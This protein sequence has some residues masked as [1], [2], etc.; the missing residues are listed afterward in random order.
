MLVGLISTFTNL[1]S[2]ITLK[3]VVQ[4]KFSCKN[5]WAV[6]PWPATSTVHHM[7]Q[8]HHF[9]E[10]TT[11]ND[12]GWMV[13]R[14]IRMHLYFLCKV[15]AK[16]IQMESATTAGIM[17]EEARNSPN[18][19]C[20]CVKLKACLTLQESGILL[21]AWENVTLHPA[22]TILSTGFYH[23]PLMKSHKPSSDIYANITIFRAVTSTRVG[24]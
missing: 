8:N 5:S 2:D 6:D 19:T 18:Y 21:W 4:K 1:P 12:W 10:W 15:E 14:I 11:T 9:F 22:Q 3:V 24:I 7:N 13:R 20:T 16:C 23:V 17:I